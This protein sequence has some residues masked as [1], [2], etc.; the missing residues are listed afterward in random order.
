[1]SVRGGYGV[2]YERNFG[3]VTFNV[4]QNPP[5]YAVVALVAGSDVPAI[6]ITTNN[7][8]PLAGV[9]S[10]LLPPVSLRHVDEHITNAYAHFWSAS[11][12]KELPAATLLSVDYTGSKGVDLY[13]INRLNGPGSG[14][15]YLGD[16]NP[17]SRE[18][19]QYGTI[20]S[21]TNGGRSL[22]NGVTFG[23][24]SRNVARMD[25]GLTRD[26][27]S[28]T[29][30]TTSARR[31]AKATTTSIWACSTRSTHRSIGV[32]RASTS[33][34]GSWRAPSGRFPARRRVS[35]GGF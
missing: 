8:G 34:T 22:H 1:M 24:E 30:R 26:T 6:P 19:P 10:T 11:F 15:V 23:V 20:N 17:A 16:A 14:A 9:G 5:S 35:P 12:Q 31:S 4:I 29:R 27:R 32:T 33:A 28:R 18:N 21:R 13:L 7:A 3:N 25:S 2:G